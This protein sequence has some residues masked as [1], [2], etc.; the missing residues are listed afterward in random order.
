MHN[1]RQENRKILRHFRQHPAA[2]RLR[3]LHELFC[4]AR[5]FLE[6]QFDLDGAILQ[7]PFGR[8]VSQPLDLGKRRR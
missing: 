1:V 6:R 2:L 3:K 4:Q 8:V 5:Q 7:R